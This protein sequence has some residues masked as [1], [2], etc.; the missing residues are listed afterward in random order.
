MLD[1]IHKEALAT[2]EG[3]SD[4]V[5]KWNKVMNLVSKKDETEIWERHI[6]DSALCMQYI[7]NYDITLADLGSGAGFPGVVL[8]I[9]GIKRVNLIEPDNKRAIF[10]R[11]ATTLSNNHIDVIEK[12]GE[13]VSIVCDILTSRAFCSVTKI[14]GYVCGD[15]PNIKVRDKIMLWKG[16]NYEMEIEEAK[17]KWD[18]RYEVHSIKYGVIL[19][20]NLI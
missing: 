5:R 8:S 13:D 12:R 9:L 16:L 11:Q 19:C 4:M 15:K 7:Q 17:Q 18:F 1:K 10:L 20:I 14:L 2:L 6:L 3:F